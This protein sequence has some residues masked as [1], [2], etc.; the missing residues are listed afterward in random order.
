MTSSQQQLCKVDV[1]AECN[2]C[3]FYSATFCHTATSNKMADENIRFGRRQGVR[4]SKSVSRINRFRISHWLGKGGGSSEMK[5]FLIVCNLKMDDG[6]LT[7]FSF[8][9]D[10]RSHFGKIAGISGIIKMVPS[11]GEVKKIRACKLPGMLIRR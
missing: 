7:Y 10:K 8:R 5:S 1:V 3:Y 4:L 2:I 6:W 11:F 9:P